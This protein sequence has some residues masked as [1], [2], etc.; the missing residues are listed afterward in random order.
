MSNHVT[1]ALAGE[2]LSSSG[3]LFSPSR[4]TPGAFAQS[5]HSGRQSCHFWSSCPVLS[6]RAPV[7]SLLEYL[8]KK[9][10]VLAAYC[11]RSVMSF[12]SILARATLSTSRVSYSTEG[13]L[14]ARIVLFLVRK[15]SL[16]GVLLSN[17][18]FWGKKKLFLIANR[19]KF[20]QITHIVHYFICNM[21]C[22]L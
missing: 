3:V 5:L 14:R 8:S 16:S 15:L 22:S 11:F 2:F 6:L 17:F 1:G 7:M 4:V 18:V 13:S 21:Y 19:K 20:C 12:L 10:Q 9:L